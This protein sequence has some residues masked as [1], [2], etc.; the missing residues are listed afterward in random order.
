MRAKG[1]RVRLPSKDLHPKRAVGTAGGVPDPN[2]CGLRIHEVAAVPIR[3]DPTRDDL[4][5]GPLPRGDVLAD[6][7][8]A[9]CRASDA[10]D[11]RAT[12]RT[13]VAEEVV[14]RHVSRVRLRRDVVVVVERQRPRRRVL[15]IDTT[16]LPGRARCVGLGQHTL[17]FGDLHARTADAGLATGTGIP[18]RPTIGETVGRIHTH[19][20]AHLADLAHRRRLGVG[21]GRW[22]GSRGVVRC[23][24]VGGRLANTGHTGAV[25]DH[26]ACAAMH[27]VGG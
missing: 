9:E 2:L 24:V 19:A 25:A 11:K 13:G 15:P 1:W 10:Y 26:S 3:V 27:L 4:R 16:I 18:A 6:G 8:A 12:I 7:G 17:H 14:R 22:V 21:L 20:A 23:G 5:R